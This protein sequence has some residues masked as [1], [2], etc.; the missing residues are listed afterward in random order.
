MKMLESFKDCDP[1]RVKRDYI[2]YYLGART[3][4]GLFII[5]F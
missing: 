1:V 5:S 2:E 3:Q 4:V